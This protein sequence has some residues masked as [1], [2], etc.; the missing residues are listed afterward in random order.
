MTL[1]D[2]P[3]NPLVYRV[4]QDI[5]GG[6][7]SINALITTSHL[8]I[9][10]AKDHSSVEFDCATCGPKSHPEEAFRVFEEFLRPKK[11]RIWFKEI[12]GL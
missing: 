10:S 5:M 6:G 8:T 7:V 9:H 3:D 2:I 12:T 11:I 1:A 4:D